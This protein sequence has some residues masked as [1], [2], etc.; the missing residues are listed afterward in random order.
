MAPGA[1]LALS[2]DLTGFISITQTAVGLSGSSGRSRAP[3]PPTSAVMAVPI[4]GRGWTR[5]AAPGA[6]SAPSDLLAGWFV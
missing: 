3:S 1:I 6:I 4:P 5:P 2:V